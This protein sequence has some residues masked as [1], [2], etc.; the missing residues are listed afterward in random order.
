MFGKVVI[1]EI[2][3][4]PEERGQPLEFIE[5]YNC[6]DAVADLSG[7]RFDEGIDYTFPN[8]TTLPP[9]KL[10][11]VAENPKSPGVIPG[12][13]HQVALASAT[14]RNMRSPF[15]LQTFELV[16][17]TKIMLQLCASSNFGSVPK[18]KT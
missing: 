5:L 16:R 3:Y 9:G 15:A 17:P 18:S 2:H 14:L 12:I 13:F 7:W 1:H 4:N 10:L 8:A 6:G 11:V